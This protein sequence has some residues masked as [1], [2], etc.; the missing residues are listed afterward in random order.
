MFKNKK[1][2]ENVEATDDVNNAEQAQSLA[3]ELGRDDESLEQNLE[4]TDPF[5]NI[6]TFT[7]GKPGFEDGRTFAG[8]FVANK[9][10]YSEKFTAGKKDKDGKTF[11]ILHILEDKNGKKFGLWSVG[12][13]GYMFSKTEIGQYVKVRYDGKAA[14]ALK[15][16]QSPS[17]EFTFWT[18]TTDHKTASDKVQA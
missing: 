16:G 12:Q 10:I 8:T 7:P 11:R 2:N 13:L 3:N 15:A 5:E 18:P 4:E 9:T 1:R 17:H 6:P 14:E